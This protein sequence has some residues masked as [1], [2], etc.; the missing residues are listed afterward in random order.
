MIIFAFDAFIFRYGSAIAKVAIVVLS[1]KAI[2]GKCDG[3]MK[4]R[5]AF[6]GEYWDEREE[7]G[8]QNEHTLILP[9]EEFSF[10]KFLTSVFSLSPFQIVCRSDIEMDQGLKL[11]YRILSVLVRAP[12]IFLVFE[13]LTHTTSIASY[14]ES[15]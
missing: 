1:R 7:T 6:R 9:R 8:E 14:F 4:E 11:A 15:L 12:S 2:C 13:T 3:E 5:S 10:N